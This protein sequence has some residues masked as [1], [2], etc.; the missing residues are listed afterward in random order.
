LSLRGL[1]ALVKPGERVGVVGRTVRDSTGRHCF[2]KLG[3]EMIF[4]YW[5][6]S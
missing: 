6:L 2:Q 4:I 5:F 1:N 3:L